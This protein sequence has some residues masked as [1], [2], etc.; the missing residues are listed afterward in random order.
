MIKMT[1]T[2]MQIHR[3]IL[4]LALIFITN[5]LYPQ[6][7]NPVSWKYT[8]SDQAEGNH[9]IVFTAIITE[10]WHVYAIKL[11]KEGPVPT[12]FTF[13]PNTSV[14][15]SGELTE[16][17]K[18]IIK[19]DEGFRFNVGM[20][21][22]KAVFSQRV[23]N[24]TDQPAKLKV[25]I[26]FQCCN[27]EICLPPFTQEFEIDLPAGS[28]I[29]TTGNAEK[30]TS[31]ENQA[32]TK[33]SKVEVPVVQASQTI[34]TEPS[35]PMANESREIKTELTVPGDPERQSIFVFLLIAFLAGLAAIVTPCV[36][37]MIPMTI[38]FFLRGSEKRGTAIIKGLVFGFSMILVYTGIGVLVSL[39]GMNAD[40]GNMLSTHWIPNTIFFLLFM[41]FAASFL[42][43]FELVLPSGLVN[44]ADKNADRKGLAGS[45]FMGVT[46]VLVSFSC[47]GPIV[48]SLLIEA[49][50]GE[51]LKP[52]LGMFFFSLAFAL[53][54]TLLA[55]FPSMLKNLPKSGGWL[56]SVKVVLGF[57]VLAFGMKFLSSMDQSYHLGIF[58]REIY[59]AVWFIIAAMLG[60]YLLGKIKFAH[61]SEMSFVSVP[62]LILAMASFVF[63][64]YLFTG[65]FGAD[66]KNL[67]ALI[68]PKSASTFKFS[69]GEVVPGAN[70]N[71]NTFCGPGK[72]D[73]LFEL[74]LGLTG[75]FDFEDGLNCA[76]EKNKPVFLDFTGHFCSN[77]KQMENQV[78]SEPEVLRL[79]KNEFVIVSL[80]TDDKTKLDE[81]QWIKAKNG[82]VL[83]TIGDIHKNFEIEKFNTLATPWYAL[84]DKDG[85]VLVPP[86]GKDLNVE[87][88]T[89]FLQSGL[90]GFKNSK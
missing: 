76:N 1:I 53:P 80:F 40:I 62:R 57:I 13:E 47:T 21:A 20:Y 59:L 4:F 10:P 36:F 24:I 15:L 84:L 75:Y 49:A 30:T 87:S 43:M 65:I 63:A 17:T 46:T 23:R 32:K 28:A 64:I 70:E 61:D 2:K 45:F 7:E 58:S 48:G 71:S 5:L 81:S 88:F 3:P 39:T 41:V 78:W 44:T 50:G 69:S 14:E 68:P 9:E 51:I 34:V 27:D 19:F 35:L 56:N 11:E 6:L 73:E 52:I 83:K 29:V 31:L 22:K 82:K 72:F 37:P 25:G 79:L 16:L 12:T 33:T 85:N 89:K 55:I 60:M 67:S 66:L 38:S 77:C 8:I 90:D 74:P 18:P 54:F 26:E 86:R 42:G